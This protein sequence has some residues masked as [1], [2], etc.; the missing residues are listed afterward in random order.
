MTENKTVTL[1]QI[2]RDNSPG[3]IAPQAGN[4]LAEYNYTVEID[5]DPIDH[6]SIPQLLAIPT[7]LTTEQE[8]LATGKLN[9][10]FSLDRNYQTDELKLFYG[11]FGKQENRFLLDGQALFNLKVQS[12]SKELQQIEITLPEMTAGDH[13][14]TITVSGEQQ[15]QDY[16]VISYLKL[17]A[18]KPETLKREKVKLLP[19]P[20]DWAAW[21]ADKAKLNIWNQLW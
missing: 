5:R 13:I 14:L 11:C 18:L 15:N 17:E 9:I 19:V 20:E 2:G 10:Y 8:C 6:P 7:I 21:I 12:N 3:K 4:W 1:W 16:Q